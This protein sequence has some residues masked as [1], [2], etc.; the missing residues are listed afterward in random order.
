MLGEYLPDEPPATTTAIRDALPDSLVQ[1]KA[2]Y[3]LVFAE[4]FDGSKSPWPTGDCMTALT[5]ITTFFSVK[6]EPCN[7]FR[8]QTRL[9]RFRVRRIENGYYYTTK[10]KTCGS[11][12]GTHGKFS[13]QIRLFRSQV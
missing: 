1:S 3:S 5:T 13:F 12:I 9:P 10:T 4:E 7:P 11:Q 6:T 2:N 8:R